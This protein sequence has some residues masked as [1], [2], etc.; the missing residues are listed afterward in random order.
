ML[1]DVV[2]VSATPNL[3]LVKYWGKRREGED[4]EDPLL[5]LPQNSSLSI[6]VGL[7]ASLQTITSVVFSNKFSKDKFFLDGTEQDLDDPEL[8]ERFIAIDRLREFAKTDARILVVSNNSFP[9]GSGMASS[10]SGLSALVYACAKA[11]DL[12][13]SESKL[14]EIARMGSGSACRS[15]YGGFVVWARGKKPDGTDSVAR[16]AFDEHYWPEFSAVIAIASQKKKRVSSRAGMKQTVATSELYK[17]RPAAA[18]RNVKLMEDAIAKKDFEKVADITIRDS[19]MM[20]ATMMDTKPP[21]IYLNDVSKGII[22]ALEDLNASEGRLVAGYTFDA[23]PNAF[24]I[25][26]DKDLDRVVTRLEQVEGIERVIK[27]RLSGGPKVMS[28]SDSLI[29][30]STFSPIL[31]RHKR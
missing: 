26:L 7:E 29:A 27:A 14:S 17:V 4:C 16:Q 20:H 6:T 8:K 24:V 9:T 13:L 18:E 19:M 25:V 10:A 15:L 11:L 1:D 3:A 28:A 30:P 5:N 31:H 23:G 12:E 22:Y 21:I 2:T